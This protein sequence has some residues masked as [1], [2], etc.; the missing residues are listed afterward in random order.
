MNIERR[1]VKAVKE[2]FIF[3]RKVPVVLVWAHRF[4]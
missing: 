2:M 3:L 4:L 1:P